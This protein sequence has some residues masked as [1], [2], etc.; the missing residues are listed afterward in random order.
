MIRQ[1]TSSRPGGVPAPVSSPASDI[2]KQPPCAAASSSSGLVFP[3][4]AATRVGSEYPSPSNAPDDAAVIA[5][6]PRAR[7]PSHETSASRTMRGMG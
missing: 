5:P 7:F 3:S 2:V 1:W 6:V 4:G